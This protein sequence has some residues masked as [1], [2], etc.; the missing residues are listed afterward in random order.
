MDGLL[1]LYLQCLAYKNER[2]S[3]LDTNKLVSMLVLSKL[4]RVA[5]RQELPYSASG[6]PSLCSTES[7]T[8]MFTKQGGMYASYQKERAYYWKYPLS[9]L[10][11]TNENNA[12]CVETVSCLPKSIHHSLASSSP[13]ALH[14]PAFLALRMAM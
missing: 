11:C 4:H 8:Q 10:V 6:S 12:F 2:I 14:F 9:L 13:A 3:T 7:G 5:T 1:A